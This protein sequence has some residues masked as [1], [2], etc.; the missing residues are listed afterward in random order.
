MENFKVSFIGLN[1]PN[2]IQLAEAARD[3]CRALNIECELV[4]DAD[5][6]KFVHHLLISDVLVFDGSIESVELQNF[7]AAAAVPGAIEHLLVV[8]RTYLPMNFM[9]ARK[10][11][12]P[13]YPFPHLTTELD[14]E[15]VTWSNNDIIVWLERELRDLASRGPRKKPF[16]L[17][18]LAGKNAETIGLAWS[19]FYSS[20][21]P[22]PNRQD[23]V[24]I[25]YRSRVYDAVKDLSQ[26]I[27]SGVTFRG[28]QKTTTFIRPGALVYERELLQPWRRW[29][30]LSLIDRI[31]DEH[32][33]LLAYLTDD[34]F[35]SWWTQGELTTLA[36]RAA[37]GT[38][39]TKVL[40]FD[41]SRR[42]VLDQRLKFVPSMSEL[43]QAR[44][45]RWYSHTD[46]LGMGPENVAF[47][48]FIHRYAR[49]VPE[50]F[51]RLAG[52]L[53]AR[54]SFGRAM[55]GM[56]EGL[57]N[58]TGRPIAPKN[59]WGDA[60]ALKKFYTDP[61]WSDQFWDDF[62]IECSCGGEIP[63]NLEIDRFLGMFPA[64][65]VVASAKQVEDAA[66]NGAL[67][68]PRCG[69]SHRVMQAAPRYLWAPLRGYQTKSEGHTGLLRFPTFVLQ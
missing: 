2:G 10:G 46:P 50:I 9:P 52:K 64:H 1:T 13:D 57:P 11:G 7:H 29:H 30:L 56:A 69:R 31:I 23:R 53:V 6:F 33:E 18:S 4:F 20:A 15:R 26:S 54:S 44:M 24:F 12:A 32:S 17:E 60:P 8:G 3:L 37:A 35:G 62:L 45:A 21:S 66:R 43:Q 19:Q 47:N 41:P 38:L 59:I 63:K 27:S 5:R 22:E 36:Y 51:F 49:N 14:S 16:T 58:P 61:V 55:E 68:C 65:M 48:R 67:L 34:Y 42:E 40:F 39:N 28:V 25:S